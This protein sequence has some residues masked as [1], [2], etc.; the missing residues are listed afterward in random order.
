MYSLLL[1]PSSQ[2]VPYMFYE[3]ASQQARAKG[4][5]YPLLILHTL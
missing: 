2:L 3:H 1:L 4:L 5:S